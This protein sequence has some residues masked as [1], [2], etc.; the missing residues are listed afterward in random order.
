MKFRTR[1]EIPS[2]LMAGR[3]YINGAQSY[4]NASIAD[5]STPPKIP[6]PLPLPLR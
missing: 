2:A 6:L 4:S 5:F 1:G 3:G